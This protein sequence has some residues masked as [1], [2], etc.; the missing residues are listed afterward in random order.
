MTGPSL[1][2]HVSHDEL[3][4]IHHVTHGEALAD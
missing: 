2:H 4:L 3:S 1:I